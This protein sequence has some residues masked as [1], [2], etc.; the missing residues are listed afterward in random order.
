M[1]T[2]YALQ[3]GSCDAVP[4]LCGGLA[5]QGA[6]PY[7][8]G[9]TPHSCSSVTVLY[10]SQPL[11]ASHCLVYLHLPFSTSHMHFLVGEAVHM[12]AAYYEKL[13]GMPNIVATVDGTHVCIRKPP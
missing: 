13:C 1:W 9:I 12:S 4:L 6:S 3:Q 2:A 11:S 5:V 10:R 8:L 7:T